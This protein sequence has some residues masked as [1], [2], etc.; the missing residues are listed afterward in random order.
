M[1]IKTSE[2]E[3]IALDY[4][5]AKAEGATN[6]WYDTVAT[7]WV[8]LDGKDRAL[9]KGWAQSFTPSTDWSHGGPLVEASKINLVCTATGWVAELGTLSPVNT[10]GPQGDD[11]G[12]VF[13]IDACDAITGPTPL[14]AAMRAFVFQTLGGTV[15]VPDELCNSIGE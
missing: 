4:A 13:Q 14:I 8:T 7:Y 11:W 5:V 12:D 6:L 10:Y 3:G 15:E 1:K 9:S 2:L